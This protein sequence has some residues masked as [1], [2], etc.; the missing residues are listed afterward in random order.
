MTKDIILKHN[1]L[2]S[3]VHRFK[4][5]KR[6]CSLCLQIKILLKLLP[7]WK[8]SLDNTGTLFSHWIISCVKFLASFN[9]YKTKEQRL[10]Q[11]LS[12]LLQLE[13]ALLQWQPALSG[14]SSLWSR[15]Q[16]PFPAAND[17]ATALQHLIHLFHSPCWPQGFAFLATMN[18]LHR[19]QQSTEGNIE[20]NAGSHP[21]SITHNPF[22]FFFF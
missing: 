21:E 11:S 5:N 16:S 9:T 15:L 13:L 2:Y 22:F 4:L 14:A 12:Y 7:Y 10:T 6:F 1:L 18:L 19:C 17:D 20:E 3:E 8:K